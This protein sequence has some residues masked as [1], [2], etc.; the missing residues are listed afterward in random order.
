MEEDNKKEIQEEEKEQDLDEDD[1][2]DEEI[3]EYKALNQDT[4]KSEKNIITD[5]QAVVIQEPEKKVEEKQA[6]IKNNI[7]NWLK[8]PTNLIFIA[9]LIF[10]ISLHLYY[11]SLTKGQPIWWDESDYMAYAK[12]ISGNGIPW[13]VDGR[14]FTIFSHAVALFFLL[15]LSEETIKFLLEFIPAILIIFLA[16]QTAKVMYKDK[17]VALIT[18]F[19]VAT[20]WVVLF[21]AN[22]FHVGIPGLVFALLSIYVFW[23]G[24]IRKEKIFKKLNANWAIPLVAVFVSLTLFVRRGFFMLGLFFFFYVILTEDLKKLF[25]NIYNWIGIGVL[26][27]LVYIWENFISTTSIIE[28]GSGY[29][30]GEKAFNLDF[31]RTIMAY[32]NIPQGINVFYLLFWLGF[33]IILIRSFL[34]FLEIRKIKGNHYL[35]GD[36]FALISILVIWVIHFY[37]FRMPGEPRQFLLLLFPMS[38]CVSRG[39]LVLADLIKKNVKQYGKILSIIF[40]VLLLV[41]GGYYQIKHADPII[42]NKIESYV[43]IK[44][45]A[46]FV[47]G[48]S[49]PTDIIL[50]LSVPQTTYYA[51]RRAFTP[52]MYMDLV[53]KGFIEEDITFEQ[54]LEKIKQNQST[55]FMIVTYSEPNHPPWMRNIQ[56]R[57]VGGQAVMTKW[58]IPFMNSSID[59][60]TGEQN[61]VKSRTFDGITFELVYAQYDAFVYEIKRE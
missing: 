42:K 6:K 47:K 16:Y 43:G 17:R 7:I 29:H 20:S 46:L 52:L 27:L 33:I 2:D 45:A 61:L 28:F 14:H 15:E 13:V 39:L 18:S 10:A 34:M 19:L 11:F 44:S 21:N 35:K 57:N 59:L 5:K 26:L 32:F 23:K 54:V 12:T 9:I 4:E 58:E 60:T 1:E 38:I 8:N 55:R 41:Y 49:E 53:R 50:T 24:Y 37:Y 51:E 56:Y 30:H 36:F 3:S 31:L 25:T 22:R 48:I 40:I